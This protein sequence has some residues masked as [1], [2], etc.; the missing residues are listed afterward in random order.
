MPFTQA[1]KDLVPQHLGGHSSAR[2]C[3]HLPSGPCSKERP[4][5]S[6]ARFPVLVPQEMPS[7]W[8]TKG[9]MCFGDRHLLTTSADC[10]ALAW[11]SQRGLTHWNHLCASAAF[12]TD[13][14]SWAVGFL[15]DHPNSGWV[16]GWGS[17][18]LCGRALHVLDG[19]G[20][21]PNDGQLSSSP[22]R[23]AV[24]GSWL[25]H[26]QEWRVGTPEAP[27][28]SGFLLCCL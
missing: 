13:A 1:H 7:L 26:F 3:P 18:C 5:G 2:P 19:L 9:C 4:G 15:W 12:T 22:C 14:G 11:E 16:A 17:A 28:P 23:S 24:A 10:Q 6:V 8:P 27:L 25:V 21:G 20:L